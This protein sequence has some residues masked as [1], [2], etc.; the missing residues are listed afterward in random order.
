MKLLLGYVIA[1]HRLSVSFPVKN[2]SRLGR[3]S[4]ITHT[5]QLLHNVFSGKIQQYAIVNYIMT[6]R[7]F[8]VLQS[9]VPSLD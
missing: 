9:V 7:G 4:K 2:Q 3:Y 1:K 8:Y 5:S 6:G